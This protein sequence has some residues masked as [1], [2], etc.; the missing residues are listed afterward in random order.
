M[1]KAQAGILES[2]SGEQAGREAPSGGASGSSTIRPTPAGSSATYARSQGSRP[3]M[4][5]Q[6]T[7]AT[8]RLPPG[9]ACSR[10]SRDERPLVLVFEDLHWADDVLLDF[11]DYLVE[12]ASGVPILVLATARPELL[13]RRPGWGGGKV[14][15]ST[16]LLSPLTLEGD[17]SAPARAPRPLGA[18]RRPADAAARARRRQPALCRGVHP[19]A[20]LSPGRGRASGDRAR[21]HLRPARHVAVRGEGAAPGRSRDREDLLAGSPRPRA[22]DARRAGCTRLRG[23][24]S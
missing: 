23:R 22:L 21:R 19:D 2:D 13:S 16:I 10:R 3:T 14:N 1:V 8:S 18:R 7:G 5:G 4:R 12:W 17:H 20:R 11:V 24:S 6:A 9:A 15:S